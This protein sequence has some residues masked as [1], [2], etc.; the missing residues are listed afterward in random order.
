[1]ERFTAKKCNFEGKKGYTVKQ[2]HDGKV[3][4]EQFIA[5]EAMSQYQL[6]LSNNGYEIDFEDM[7]E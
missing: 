6:Y 2:I 7:W 5:L 4:C 3:V 1:M